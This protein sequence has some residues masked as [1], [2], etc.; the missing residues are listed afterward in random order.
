M[1]WYI[2]AINDFTTAGAL[3]S[4]SINWQDLLSEEN[5]VSHP[6]KEMLFGREKEQTTNTG[7]SARIA[8]QCTG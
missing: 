2:H 5:N 8:D 6:Y 3:R 7:Q 1:L 4:L